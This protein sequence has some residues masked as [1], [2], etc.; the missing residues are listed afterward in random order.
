VIVLDMYL[1]GEQVEKILLTKH[2]MKLLKYMLQIFSSVLY[3]VVFV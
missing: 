3:Y 2:I 1:S